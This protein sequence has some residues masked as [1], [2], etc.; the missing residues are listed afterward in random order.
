VHGR[1]HL[2]SAVWQS[3]IGIYVSTSQRQIILSLVATAQWV[4]IVDFN[5]PECQW[6][7]YCIAA[8]TLQVRGHGGVCDLFGINTLEV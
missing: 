2:Q 8:W 3:Q 7:L 6:K 1:G 4:R 5:M